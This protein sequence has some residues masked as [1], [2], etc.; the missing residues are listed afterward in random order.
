MSIQSPQ[1]LNSLYSSLLKK[2]KTT[3]KNFLGSQTLSIQQSLI[4]VFAHLIQNN[5]NDVVQETVAFDMNYHLDFIVP[6]SLPT[7][8]INN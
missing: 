2:T 4:V 8:I 1:Q 7:D 5:L 3:T 6:S